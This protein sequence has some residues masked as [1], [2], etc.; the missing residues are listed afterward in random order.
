VTALLE[1]SDLTRRYG[2]LTAL[3]S[4]SV[5]VAPGEIVAVLGPNG[6]GKSTLMR[7]CAGLIAPTSGRASVCGV[8]VTA[9]P[10]FVRSQVGLVLGD[11]GFYDAMSVR[12]YLVFFAKCYGMSTE[13]AGTRASSLLAKVGLSDR[14]ESRIAG[15]SHGMRQK[16]AL[17][18]A[19]LHDPPVLMLDEPT[20]GLDPEAAAR[21][22]DDIYELRAASRGVLLCTHLLHEA[23]ELADRVVVLQRGRAIAYETPSALKLAATQGRHRVR[24]VLSSTSR[25]TV[26]DLA[27]LAPDQLRIEGNVITFD[28]A[29]PSVTN[30]AVIRSLIAAGHDVVTAE[31]TGSSL[32]AAYLSIV[33]QGGVP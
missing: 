12:A 7:V 2:S 31:T 11:A 10:T 16:V 15:L 32:E 30:P 19:L 14:A 3:E 20:N 23:D 25:P 24:I 27:D 8:D 22:R 13:E 17:A 26:A 1:C 21:F 4:V 9:D 28:T 33:A 6:A 5:S 29:D 18:R